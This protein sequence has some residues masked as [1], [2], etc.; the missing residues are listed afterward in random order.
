MAW[1]IWVF[2]FDKG[3]MGVLSWVA[4]KADGELIVCALPVRYSKGVFNNPHAINGREMSIFRWG[5]VSIAFC[6]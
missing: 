5:A 2:H 6:R 4:V 3:S 1:D